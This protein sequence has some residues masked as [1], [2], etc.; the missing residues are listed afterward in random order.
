MQARPNFQDAP[1]SGV[2]RGGVV[3]WGL[4]GLGWGWF[5]LW[6]NGQEGVHGILHHALGAVFCLPRLV[7]VRDEGAKDAGPSGEEEDAVCLLRNSSE[8]DVDYCK[9]FSW[10]PHHQPNDCLSWSIK[11]ARSNDAPQYQ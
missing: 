7:E 8:S 10:S 4:L 9:G 11:M 6:S 1:G 5:Q 3:G 2:G